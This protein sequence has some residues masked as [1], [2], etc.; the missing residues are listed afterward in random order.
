MVIYFLILSLSF[1]L[2]PVR[3]RLKQIPRPKRA[4]AHTHTHAHT[5]KHARTHARTRARALAE[6]RKRTRKT[7]AGKWKKQ[8][9]VACANKSQKVR[10]L[11]E[12]T[13]SVT[14]PPLGSRLGL[15]PLLTIGKV[16]VKLQALVYDILPSRCRKA[17][18]GVWV[19][20]SLRPAAFRQAVR[21][22]R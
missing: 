3:Q 14:S 15:L 4:R 18:F 22:L 21:V 8:Q 2:S 12:V 19:S 1:S 7:S 10:L 13:T 5:H 11:V 16:S 6:E 20:V 17:V 9:P